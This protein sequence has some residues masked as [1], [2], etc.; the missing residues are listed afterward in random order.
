[1]GDMIFAELIL[2]SLFAIIAGAI[3]IVVIGVAIS[4]VIFMISATKVIVATLLEI[5]NGNEEIDSKKVT[6]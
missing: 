3:G 1:M 2:G 4:A 5:E 6:K